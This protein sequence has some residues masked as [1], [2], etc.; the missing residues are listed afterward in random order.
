[1]PRRTDR[2]KHS[3][4]PQAL[5]FGRSTAATACR[6]PYRLIGENS[7]YGNTNKK[8]K[9]EGTKRERKRE[10][11]ENKKEI[12][13]KRKS[14][15]KIKQTKEKEKE[16]MRNI[17]RNREREKERRKKRERKKKRRK[18]CQISC[19]T[20]CPL[21]MHDVHY[22]TAGLESTRKRVLGNYICVCDS[23]N[24]ICTC[25]KVSAYFNMVAELRS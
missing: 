8:I 6:W 2:D 10:R 23:K 17:K 9:E 15:D 14:V 3:R 12:E 19:C 18:R 13:G 20:T 1:M 5:R 11:K 25:S 24:N 21:Y 16:T 4:L 22:P 7:I